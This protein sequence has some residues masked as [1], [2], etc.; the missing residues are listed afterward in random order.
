MVEMI[1]QEILFDEYYMPL[2]EIK[3]FD[4]LIENKPFS[5][6][7]TN[8]KQEVHEKLVQMSS[9]NDSTTGNLLVVN[10]Y[11]YKID[12]IILPNSTFG[13]P[14]KSKIIMF[15]FFYFNFQIILKRKHTFFLLLINFYLIGH[16]LKKFD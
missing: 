2:V 5:N 4:A 10:V 7:P 8:R 16:V 11:Q 9:N 12:N 1:L 3:D 6:Q 13:R 14:C 15:N